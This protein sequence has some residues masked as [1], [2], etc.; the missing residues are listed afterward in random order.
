MKI[1]GGAGVPDLRFERYRGTLKQGDWVEYACETPRSDGFFEAP[2]GIENLQ[3]CL[4]RL[5]NLRGEVTSINVTALKSAAENP[6]VRGLPAFNL[7]SVPG[8]G[9][10]VQLITTYLGDNINS[11]FSDSQARIVA[12]RSLRD[13]TELATVRNE[14]GQSCELG[15]G[16][17]KRADLPAQAEAL[18]RRQNEELCTG[19]A[20]GMVG[21]ALVMGGIRLA[22]RA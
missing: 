10:L 5:V 1:G 11:V 17:L 16:H 4:A 15:L 2:A 3:G 7:C 19:A 9:A 21:S 18:L 12:M 14:R 22:V 8:Q 6:I 13:G 20:V